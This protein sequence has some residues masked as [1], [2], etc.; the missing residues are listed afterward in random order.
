M[1]Q[2]LAN[3]TIFN[4]DHIDIE[5]NNDIDIGKGVNCSKRDSTDTDGTWTYETDGTVTNCTNK[6]GNIRCERGSDQLPYIQLLDVVETD[7]IQM[8]FIHVVLKGAVLVLE[9]INKM[10]YRICFLTVS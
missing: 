4:E 10:T 1:N 9:C 2:C 5:D 6:T 7:L 8:A 3:Y